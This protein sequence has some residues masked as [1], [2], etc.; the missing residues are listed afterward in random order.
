M[1]PV[2]GDIW[3]YDYLWRRQHASGETKGRKP[4]AV[5]LVAAVKGANGRTHLFLLP[6][7]SQ[8]PASIRPAVEIPE[9]ERRRAGLDDLPLW[10]M[11]DEYN[12]D[13]LELSYY[14]DGD[15]RIGRFSA[16]FHA[17]TLRAFR[18]IAKARRTA[19]VPRR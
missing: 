8:P 4:R 13:V 6:I 17:K 5:S 19:G 11:L 12:Y 18:D 7:T 15:A 9:I 2:A 16:A 14:F 10:V 3:R 1:P